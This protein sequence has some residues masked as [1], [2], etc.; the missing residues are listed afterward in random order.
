MASRGS[1]TPHSDIEIFTFKYLTHAIEI[2]HLQLILLISFFPGRLSFQQVGGLENYV[3][4]NYEKF[5]YYKN[6]TFQTIGI[7][8]IR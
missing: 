3:N 1:I 6:G 4:N 2:R 8:L 7:Y 5:P